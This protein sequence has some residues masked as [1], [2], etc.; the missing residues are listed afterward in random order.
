[1]KSNDLILKCYAE[2][3]EGV[4]VAV[5]LDFN[6]AAQADS[7]QEVKAKLESMISFYVKEALTIDVAYADQLLNRRAPLTSWI[8]YYSI[9]L[10]NF[11]HEYIHIALNNKHFTFNEIIPMRP[12]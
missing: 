11:I 7:Y 10:R 12:A 4:W 5:C 8:K 1:M 3:E 2:Q 6:L 9:V